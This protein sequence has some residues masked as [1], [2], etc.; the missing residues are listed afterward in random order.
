[1]TLPRK[2]LRAACRKHRQFEGLC[3]CLG[4]KPCPPRTLAAKNRGV[5][6][7]ALLRDV[8]EA[9]IRDSSATRSSSNRTQKGAQRSAGP[10]PARVT[11]YVLGCPSKSR[12]E[13]AHRIPTPRLHPWF[14]APPLRKGDAQPGFRH[15]RQRPWSSA[16]SF[17][18]CSTRRCCGPP[19]AMIRPSQ[20]GRL[21]MAVTPGDRRLAIPD[22]AVAG[23]PSM[24][25]T[26]THHAMLRPHP[27]GLRRARRLS[28]APQSCTLADW[29][30]EH[31]LPQ[32]QPRQHSGPHRWRSQEIVAKARLPRARRFE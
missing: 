3:S 17:R 25:A 4:S 1:M 16:K 14:A 19:P 6:P 11:S 2:H 5:S 27:A 28:P 24:R 13:R 23:D 32:M 12:N 10:A 18:K 26:S 29:S 15:L 9:S 21:W 31:R 20:T 30:C 22:A 7:S 8:N